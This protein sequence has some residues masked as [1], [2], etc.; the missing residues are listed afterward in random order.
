MYFSD[1]KQAWQKQNRIISTKIILLFSDKFIKLIMSFLNE[2][3]DT[4]RAPCKI[5]FLAS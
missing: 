2:R 3:I 1:G 5:F 4:V